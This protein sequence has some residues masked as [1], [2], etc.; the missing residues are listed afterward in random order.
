L[1]AIHKKHGHELKELVFDRES[2]IAAFEIDGAGLGIIITL[3][4]RGQH[5]GLIEIIIRYLREK[6]RSTKISVRE[7]YGYIT[8]P[9]M[10]KDLILDTA[11]IQNRI[12]KEGEDLTPFEKFTGRKVDMLRDFR[13]EWG[14]PVIVKKPKGIS[15]NLRPVGE[16]GI[17]ARRVMDSTGVIKVF[18]VQ[19]NSFGHRLKFQRSD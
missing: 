11:A 15:A 17:V 8:P 12:P 9:Q 6:A 13:C 18:L 5:V 3:K 7:L 19:S 16:W 4:A 10:N 2:A 1:I 14:E